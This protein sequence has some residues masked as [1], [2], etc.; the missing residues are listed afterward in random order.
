M[1]YVSCP[2]NYLVPNFVLFSVQNMKT[3]GREARPVMLSC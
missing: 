1:K 2:A 3:A